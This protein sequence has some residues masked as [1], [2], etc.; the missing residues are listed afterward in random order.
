M[1]RASFT[2]CSKRLTGRN[3][4]TSPISPTNAVSALTGTSTK[5]LTNAMATVKSDAE[6]ELFLEFV[7]KFP[8][9]MPP[10]TLTYTSFRRKY[11]F[12]IRGG[13]AG[14]KEGTS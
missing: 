2:R 6:D 9:V 3:S 7:S 13:L 14:G 12:H 10:T 5:L 8:S 4:P 11:I 1:R